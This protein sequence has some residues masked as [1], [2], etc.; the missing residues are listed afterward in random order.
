MKSIRFIL[1]SRSTSKAV[2]VPLALLGAAS[3]SH[4]A[5]S[6]NLLVDPGY[7]TQATLPSYAAVVANFN[8]TKE[9]WGTENGVFVGSENGVIPRGGSRML[10][11]VADGGVT[12]ATVQF[13]SLAA[14]SSEI[15]AGNASFNMNTLFN[16]S[17]D[18]GAPTA[19]ITAT[20]F[21]GDTSWGNPIGS[22][23][24]TSLV[25]D[26]AP[27]T[28]QNIAVGGNIPVGAGW[29]GFQV[30]FNN[31]SLGGFQGYVDATSELGGLTVTTVPEPSGTM[32]LG[33]GASIL[34]VRRR[35]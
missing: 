18:R 15:A 9:T 14:Y 29:I 21:A 4:A 17:A 19:S 16:T 10:R 3:L 7:E 2:I 32:L 6:A 13:I 33:I 31:A 27:N 20:F 24:A 25:L 22:G 1:K 12:T 26:T 30:A 23:F 28:W 8:T 5:T 34:L 11:M 35:K